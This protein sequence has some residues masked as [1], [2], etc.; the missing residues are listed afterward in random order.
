[1]SAENEMTQSLPRVL[2]VDDSRIVRATLAKHLK[3]YFDLVERGDGEAGW[4]ALLAD[5]QIQVV[6]SDISMPE[7][8]GLGLL[9]RIRS[10]AEPRIKHVPVIIISGEEEESVKLKA[11]SKGA[12]DFVSKSTDKVELVTRVGAMV[13]MAKTLADLR[14]AKEATETQTTTDTLTGLGTPHLLQLQGQQAF[15]F[16]QRHQGQLGAI[17][18][19]FDGFVETTAGLPPVIVDQALGL[20]A[21]LIANKCRKEDIIAYQGDYQITV[22]TS[23]VD[24]AESIAL[25][26]RLYKA[27]AA[28]KIKYRG[29]HIRTTVSVGAANTALDFC[30]SL[31]DL[32]GLAGARMQR[33][34]DEGGNR[35]IVA[36][37]PQL[38]IPLPMPLIQRALQMLAEGQTEALNPHLADLMRK[39]LP[40]VDYANRQ[41]ELDIP[42]EKLNARLLSPN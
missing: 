8:D 21:K 19:K 42:M 36:D 25:A 32:L 34:M 11:S 33:A 31:D 35:A 23:T 27:I 41:L 16:A 2:I 1:M 13:Q 38:L 29:D 24:Y 15:S 28:A 30:S 7:L 10:F 26:N 9:E 12:N 37:Q 3:D 20:L 22:L 39:I 4:E 17:V 40:L 5:D 14:N 6:I 18:L